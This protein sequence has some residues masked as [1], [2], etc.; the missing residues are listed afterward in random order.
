[1]QKPIVAI[2]FLLALSG[3]ASEQET[4]FETVDKTAIRLADSRFAGTDP[5]IR[6]RDV[7]CGHQELATWIREEGVVQLFLMQADPGC[8]VNNTNARE[9]ELIQLFPW[10]TKGKLADGGEAV[11]VDSSLGPIWAMQFQRDD[12]NCFLFRHNFGTISADNVDAS[13][14]LIVGFFCGP[15]NMPNTASDIRR[16]VSSITVD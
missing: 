11:M 10:L 5:T 1:M 16:F 12:R 15:A 14:N 2:L 9:D 13:L 3:C 4:K 6:A 7:F 8:V